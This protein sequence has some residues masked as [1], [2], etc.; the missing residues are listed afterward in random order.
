MQAKREPPPPQRYEFEQ[1]QFSAKNRRLGLWSHRNPAPPWE[2]RKGKLCARRRV[3][4]HFCWGLNGRSR[5][6]IETEE[7]RGNP[8]WLSAVEG[9]AIDRRES[10]DVGSL[11]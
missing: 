1:A 6:G 2:W 10:G 5:P 4:L 7:P 9:I 8:G 11:A 3:R